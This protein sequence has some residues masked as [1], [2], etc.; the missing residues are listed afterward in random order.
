MP[1]AQSGIRI[2]E[3]PETIVEI[4]AQTFSRCENLRSITLPKSLEVLSQG[5]FEKSAITELTV[6]AS[7]KTIESGALYECKDLKY[8]TILNPECDFFRERTV[9]CKEVIYPETYDCPVPDVA[10]GYTADP[11]MTNDPVPDDQLHP[12][13]VYDFTICGYKNSTAQ[14]YAEANNIPF[15]IYDPDAYEVRDVVSM[16]R[17][18]LGSGASGGRREYD[19]NGDGVTDIYDLALLKRKL[20]LDKA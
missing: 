5:V 2:I 16:Q 3:L 15:E 10:A 1:F 8:V 9:I 19:L 11:V 17:F 7:V 6:P 13:I 14:Q 20:T 4:G 18:L 12:T